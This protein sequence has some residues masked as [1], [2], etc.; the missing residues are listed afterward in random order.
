[1]AFYCNHIAL[2][3][4]RSSDDFEIYAPVI[5]NG[6]IIAYNKELDNMYKL[7]MGQKREHLHKVS[8]ESY[9]QIQEILEMQPISLPY[10]LEEGQ[11]D[12]AVMDVTKAALL[13]KFNFASLSE[14]DYVSFVLVVRKDII[15]T[16]AFRDFLDVYNKT[17]EELSQ[18]ETLITHMGM[19]KEFWDKVKLKFLSL[20]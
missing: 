4:V 16:R 7:G 3:L 9:P 2:H 1:M 13:P 10:S 20:E 19:T 14:N 12:G 11:I 18:T 5:M 15:D 6:E 17:I 8:K